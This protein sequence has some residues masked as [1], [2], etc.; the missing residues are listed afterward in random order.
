[1]IGPQQGAPPAAAP[2][3][4]LLLGQMD[5][6]RRSNQILYA[7]TL[8][9]GLALVALLV[10]R[11]VV[12]FNRA[13]PVATALVVLAGI[14]AAIG[15]L[16]VLGY[17]MLKPRGGLEHAARQA[18]RA[19]GL[20]D[21]MLSAL[22][23]ARSA[24]GAWID[25][26]LERAAAHAQR[27]SCARLV[28]T[29]VPARLIGIVA[30][31]AVLLLVSW[32][33]TP[34]LPAV[35]RQAQESTGL[36]PEERRQVQALQAVIA[37]A[38]DT[39]PVRSLRAALDAVTRNDASEEERR[40]AL[41]QAQEAVEQGKLEAASAREGMYRL[42][43][44]LR[45]QKGMEEVAQALGEGDAR[46]AAQLL[47]R[48]AGAPGAE[49]AGSGASAGA[50]Q[51]ARE[52]D[53]ERLLQEAAQARGKGDEG[54]TPSSVAMKEA[55]DRL[56]KIASELE[57]QGT[58]SNSTKLLQQLQ[59]AVAQRSTMSAGRFAQQ[60][61]QNSSP[62]TETGNTV[63]PGGRMF[64]SGAVA[65]ESERSEQQEG[66]KAGEAQG[67][68]VADPL[69]GQK[70][71]PLSVRLKQEALPQEGEPEE[72]PSESWFYAESTEQKSAL[73]ARAVQAHAEFAEAQ[74]TPP[75]AISVQH[76]R[77]VKEYFM[78]LREGAK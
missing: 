29:R 2:A 30:G 69:L 22:Y 17:A 40:R 34:L 16:V 56:N 49:G 76:R 78:N 35:A 27:L 62:G 8:L 65:Q 52:K 10:W 31:V 21:E 47:E 36:M 45:S 59:L 57:V 33:L 20:R 43:Q 72:K 46:K 5:R 44:R 53:L 25:A 9:A 73:E 38:P 37:Q 77:T 55:V 75:E 74:A 14:G 66:S 54:A 7:V 1:M 50:G 51:R 48:K 67:E 71:T 32:H 64:R 15:F 61:A 4:L 26:Q 41:A 23:F 19:A 68:S 58:L 28:P 39:G 24:G 6:R 60:A 12:V 13:A 63:M 18:D 42:G 3:V 70:V 11:L